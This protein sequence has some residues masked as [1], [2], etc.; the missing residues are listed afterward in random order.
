M[1]AALACSDAPMLFLI[2]ET[3]TVRS[4]QDAEA[5]LKNAIVHALQLKW[6][7]F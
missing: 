1:K 4:A 5:I 2:A 3:M 7:S 6:P